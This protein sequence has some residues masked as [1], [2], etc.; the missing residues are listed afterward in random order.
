MPNGLVVIR[1]ML[2]WVYRRLLFCF[3]TLS[4]HVFSTVAA[5][6]TEESAELKRPIIFD[7]M[8]FIGKPDLGLSQQMKFIYE[9]ESTLRDEGERL[10]LAGSSETPSARTIEPYFF[11]RAIQLRGGFKYVVIDIESL[12]S[13][14]DATAI[15]Y[16]ELAKRAA[17]SSNVAMWNVG[18]RN[19]TKSRFRKFNHKQWQLEFETRKALVDTNDFSI[20]GFYF[21]SDDSIDTW[22]S[23]H[24]PRISEARRLCGDKPLFVTIAPHYFDRG[25]PWPFV[26]GNLFGEALDA[27][28]DQNVDGIVLWSF[29]GTGQL[30]TWDRDW[31]WVSELQSRSKTVGR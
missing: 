23:R 3:L 1:T 30:Q 26:A 6:T 19:V 14:E 5:E 20:L 18:P 8:T 22:K 4:L 12:D 10:A 2:T 13:S 21:K 7:A 31:A 16:V 27:L 15:S 24:I 9:W 29:E 28:S 17:S 25:K 11:G